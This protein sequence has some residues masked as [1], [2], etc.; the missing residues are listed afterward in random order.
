MK[1]NL[2]QWRSHFK[3]SYNLV[4]NPFYSV[5][6][7]SEGLIELEPIGNKPGTAQVGAISK[8]QK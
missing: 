8:A 2:R 3:Y 6:Y 1:T 5:F 4:W 7:C